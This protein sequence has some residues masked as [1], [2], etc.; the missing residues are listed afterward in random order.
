MTPSSRATAGMVPVTPAATTGMAV[1]RGAIL[2]RAHPATGAGDARRRVAPLRPGSPASRLGA[3]AG[4]PAI[5]ASAR[6]GLGRQTLQAVE[7]NLFVVQLVEKACQFRREADRLLVRHVGSRARIRRVSSSRRRIGP[8]DGGSDSSIAPSSASSPSSGSP[9]G[10]RRGS[11]SGW[12]PAA[13]RN[14]SRAARQARRLGSSTRVSARSSR[15]QAKSPSTNAGRNGRSASMVWTR[16][17]ARSLDRRRPRCEARQHG[18]PS[19][20]ASQ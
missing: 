10:I 13:R 4:K 11:S 15:S 1:R 16:I 17:I 5:P 8:I 3:A 14:A 7:R 9:I 18:H 2:P 6:P 12:P 19:P 20:A